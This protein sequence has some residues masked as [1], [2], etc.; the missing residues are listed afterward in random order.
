MNGRK[1][2]M[3]EDIL[4]V[5]EKHRRVANDIIRRLGEQFFEKRVLIAIGGESGS[6]KS[7]LAHSLAK[8]LKEKNIYA[9][10]IHTDDFYKVSPKSRT[11]WRKSHDIAK[12]G[13]EEYDWDEIIR[14]INAF[15]KK[16][17]CEM[18]CVDLLT[19]QTDMLTT[20]FAEVQ[21][22][23]LEG[24]YALHAKT[25]IKIFIDLTFKETKKA[26]K[27]RGKEPQ[28]KFRYKILKQEHSVIHSFK[29]NVDFIVNKAYSLEN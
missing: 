5:E 28:S 6:G 13:V 16:E 27:L 14:V 8:Q 29:D 17:R 21:I 23:I 12:I 2:E 4:L 19:D 24:L 22:L 20:N 18:P 10:L 7:E 9:K 1:K 11:E 26:Q 3:L 15:Q 25:D